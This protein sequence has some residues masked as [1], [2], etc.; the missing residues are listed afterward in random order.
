MFLRLWHYHLLLLL[1]VT[2]LCGQVK[3]EEN[4]KRKK[5]GDY[6]G[7]GLKSLVLKM[8]FVTI[9]AFS[10]GAIYLLLLFLSY[11]KYGFDFR[12]INFYLMLLFYLLF[13][14]I[15]VRFQTFFERKFDES[16]KTIDMFFSVGLIISILS[17][18]IL[19]ITNAL[20]LPLIVF[21]ILRVRV[22]FS[23]EYYF[24]IFNVSMIGILVF[25][26]SKFFEIFS[27]KN[28]VLSSLYVAGISAVYSIFN[29]IFSFLFLT[30]M[31]KDFS[32]KYFNMLI[33]DGRFYNI[34]STSLNAFLVYFLYRLIGISAIPVSFFTISSIQLG[35]Y[36]ATKYRN[37]KLELLMAL[38]KSLEEKDS[39]TLGHG[40]NVAKL[41][42]EI[43][44]ELG[45]SDN[46]LKLLEIAGI[47]HDVGKIGI[48]DIIISK[49]DKLTSEEYE[50]MKEHSVKGYEILKNITEYKDTVA[51][52]VL[53]HHER[54]DGNG[55]PGGLKEEEIPL[56]SRILTISDVFDAITSDRPYR[57]AWSR[58]KAIA[59][60][61]DNSDIIFDPEIVNVFL[62]V[63]G[64]D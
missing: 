14:F 32:K 7:S 54:W 61:K 41:S 17:T 29:L 53:H 15:P 37:A 4:K 55:Y 12:D 34:L 49:M 22:L 40:E 64:E 47:L 31:Y 23:K 26:V 16:K 24:F 56:F 60:I 51:T 43:A 36:Y 42:V 3:V 19:K 48:P 10:L 57:R 39:Y 62:K 59:F 18:I 45:F 25:V 5:A 2:L 58:K 35:N 8:N 27:F 63:I 28:I 30:F 33:G 20:V 52:W 11:V 9:Y 46:D 38:A 6:V 50:I 21:L 1:W 13:E 44:K